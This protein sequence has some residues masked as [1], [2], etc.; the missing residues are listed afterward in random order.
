MI[1]N[2]INNDK[3]RYRGGVTAVVLDWSGTLIDPY[4][5]APTEVFV[6]AFEKFNLKISY[7]EARGPMGIKKDLHIAKL[8]E[9]ESVREQFKNT[10][11][12][13]PNLDP[14][15]EDVQNIYKQFL[16]IVLN[17]LPK[18]TQ[19]VPGAMEAINYLKNRGIKV[20][21]TTGFT[22]QM[23]EIIL[24]DCQK[25]GFVPDCAMAGDS[26]QNGSRPKPFMLFRCLEMVNA[27]PVSSVIKIDD[28]V[29]GIGEA[30]A[31]G[32]WSVGV[33]RYSNYMNINS[34][35]HNLTEEEIQERL[36]KSRKRLADSGAH[37][38]IDTLAS[39]PNLVIDV[40]YR[41]A[42]GEAP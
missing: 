20:C 31:A 32:C 34:L 2:E 28:T 17:V 22:E 10:Y 29:S 41:L 3:R 40:E 35:D 33:A 36:I 18:Y 24:E 16:P 39:I 27:G 25:A 12:R 19:L 15:G 6:K 23:V 4:V 37:Y 21:V 11:G 30:H 14:G 8:L 5:I 7:E 38:V 13:E 9:L 1:R 26:V 42:K